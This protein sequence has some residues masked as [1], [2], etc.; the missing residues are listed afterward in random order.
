MAATDSAMRPPGPPGTAIGLADAVDKP[1]DEYAH[2][3]PIRL[4]SVL[5]GIL[6]ELRVRQVLQS[7]S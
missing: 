4:A 3:W 5:I 2:L 7:R 1:R 6:E